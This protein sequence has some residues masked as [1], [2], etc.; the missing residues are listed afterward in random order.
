MAATLGP[1]DYYT[2]PRWS[3]EIYC[4][5]DLGTTPSHL[6]ILA[7]YLLVQS[8]ERYKSI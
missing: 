4:D 2:C 3:K 8:H 7:I 1:G 5:G 6:Q